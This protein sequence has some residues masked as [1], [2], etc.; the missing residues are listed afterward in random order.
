[1]RVVTRFPIKINLI[2][3]IWYMEYYSTFGKKYV[4]ILFSWKKLYFCYTKKI[5]ACTPNN[6]LCWLVTF[7]RREI[8]GPPVLY[9]KKYNL[10][11]VCRISYILF[12]IK[13]RCFYFIY[14]KN[15]NLW[16]FGTNLSQPICIKT[17]SNLPL[18]LTK[19]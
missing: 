8:R 16:Y 12:S 7:L 10:F 18:L 3:F 9:E 6:K 2:Q 5:V 17:M 4:S 1:M 19:S 15:K 11:L 13:N 14:Q